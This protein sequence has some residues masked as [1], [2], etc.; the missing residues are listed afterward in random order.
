[1]GISVINLCP[2]REGVGVKNPSLKKMAEMISLQG[3]YG[4]FCVHSLAHL[5]QLGFQLFYLLTYFLKWTIMIVPAQ[6]NLENY[7]YIG[8]QPPAI[9][10][11]I[12]P[13]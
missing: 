3:F 8:F 9:A 4:F 11:S 7:I 1:M 10:I 5:T 6:L 13:Y 2:M 12:T